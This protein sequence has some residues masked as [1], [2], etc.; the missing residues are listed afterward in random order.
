MTVQ[1]EAKVSLTG[2]GDVDISG[3]GRCSVTRYG[4]GEVRCDGGG[5]TDN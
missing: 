5:G 2:S 1:E 4:S 3:P